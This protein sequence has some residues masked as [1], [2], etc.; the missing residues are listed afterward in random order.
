M[1]FWGFIIYLVG[2]LFYFNRMCKFNGDKLSIKKCLLVSI[3]WLPS[4]LI[5]FYSLFISERFGVQMH[6]MLMFKPDNVNEIDIDPNLKKLYEES[7]INPGNDDEEPP[8]Q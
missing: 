4:T 3:M 8:I 6:T 5:E 2:L 1:L 7:Q